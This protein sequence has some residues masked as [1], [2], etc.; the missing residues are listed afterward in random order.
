MKAP[1]LTLGPTGIGDSCQGQASLSIRSCGQ[2]TPRVIALI[3]LGRAGTRISSDF[4]RQSLA[5]RSDGES[6]TD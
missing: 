4:Q 6:V 5:R 3:D 1:D 2:T